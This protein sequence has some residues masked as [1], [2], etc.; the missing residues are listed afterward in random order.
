MKRR[1][2]DWVVAMAVSALCAAGIASVQPG[3]GTKL[4]KYGRRDD[5]FV[6]P[7]PKQLRAMTLGYK[8]TGADLLWAK[9][10]VEHGV[11]WEE[12]RAFPDIP[13]YLDGILALDPNH[14]TLYDFLD[15]LL[16]FTPKGAS[17]ESA[18]LVRAYFERGI[19]DRP[20]DAAVWLR[21]GEFMA[22]LS[23][24]YLKDQDEIQAW[25]REGA[26]AITRAVELG[27]DPDRGLGATAILT[28]TGERKAAIRALQRRYV[29]TDNLQ[30]R[31]E[32]KQRL[33][34]LASS[35]EAEAAIGIVEQEWQA[36]FPFMSRN[37]TLLMGPHRD[38]SACAGPESRMQRTCA[39]DWNGATIH[40]Q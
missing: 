5:I 24:S 19:R 36:R 2:L 9:L 17:E 28:K 11:H 26:L 16:L 29:L 18:R 1:R 23:P 13:T 6:L 32:I 31:R 35:V 40:A 12:R 38:P 7:P 39:P 3:L 34:A 22:F 33:E 8:A 27:A 15:S 14:P 21:Y 4:T 10:I 37:A 20:N 25:K 30:T